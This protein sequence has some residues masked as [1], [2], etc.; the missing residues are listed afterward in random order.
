M[1][2]KFT[3]WSVALS[4]STLLLGCGGGGESGST[5][6]VPPPTPTPPPVVQT[7][8]TVTKI[9][10]AQSHV[11][12]GAGLSWTTASDSQSLQLVG[13]R[14][15]LVTVNIA[16]ADASNPQLQAWRNSAQIGTMALS[17][18]SALPAT[19][20]N[21][22]AFAPDRW[23]ASVPA[24]WIVPGVTFKVVATNYSVSANFLP[25][26]GMD[27]ELAINILPFYLFGAN[28]V[29]TQPY[30]VTRA[31]T[32]VR[33]AEF[34]AKLPIAKLQVNAIGRIDWPRLV[35]PPRSDSAGIKQPAYVLTSMDQQ[36]DGYAAMGAV[37]GLI[38][39]MKSANGE[40]P[41]NNAYYASLLAIDA[42]SGKYHGPGGGLGTVGGGTAV[43]DYS[44]GGIYF[45]ELGHAF[46]LNHAGGEFDAGKFPYPAG[47]LKGSAWGYDFGRKQFLNPLIPVG[48]SSYAGCSTS[49][50]L[51][52][53]GSCYKQDPM[54]GGA[55]D[56][57]P[58]YAYTMFADFYAGK[59]QRWFEGKTTVNADG[60]HAFSGGRIFVDAASAT[61]YS[62]WDNISRTRVPVSATTTL[63]KGLYGEINRGLP[64]EKNV[65]VQ[66]IAI[67]MSKAGTPGATQI[68]PPLSRI[69]NLVQTYDPTKLQDM[70]EIT[71]NTGTYPWYCHASG[72]DYSVRV[73]YA[74]ASVI[75]RVLVGGFRD[76]FSPTVAPPAA[77]SDPTSGASFRSWVINVPGNKVISKIELLDTPMVWTGMPASPAVL[78]SR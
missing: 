63:D 67:T 46:S 61:G 72:C 11:I 10:F 73:T 4:L 76:W 35:V 39:G 40:G 23:S 12:P 58:G 56:Q 13:G 49:R 16:Q 52:A 51:N 71:A 22:T 5:P 45:H 50:Q 64:I 24:S 31:P 53:T 26:V 3:T 1:H 2:S 17:I 27:S 9:E 14:E 25:L 34:L 62:R 69:G 37:L 29:N 28:D 36:K 41:T 21:G 42:G 15:A 20:A 57:A 68:Y 48:A 55:G 59:I 43:G 77:S 18:A 38:G 44:F 6:G 32:E 78:A 8:L 7:P 70:H 66:T 60:T 74:D 30:S 33:Q 54:Q 47:S 65:P 75:H 19:E